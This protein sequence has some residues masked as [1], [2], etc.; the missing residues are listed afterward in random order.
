MSSLAVHPDLAAVE[1]LFRA[2][3]TELSVQR[4]AK[5]VHENARLRDENEALV[6]E[7]TGIDL[8]VRRLH[9]DLDSVTLQLKVK[10]SELKKIV[11][12]KQRV[13]ADLTATKTKAQESTK[14]AEGLDAK[15]KKQEGE[16]KDQLKVKSDELER[17]NEFRTNLKLVDD[18]EKEM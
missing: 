2:L 8:S 14:M 9:G 11:Q 10:E 18:N 12:E 7:N 13:D 16:I 6:K 5:I 4:L 1:T 17:L 3:S 15:F